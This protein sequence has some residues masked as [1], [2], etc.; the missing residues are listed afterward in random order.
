MATCLS[1]HLDLDFH[2]RFHPPHNSSCS[3]FL[4]HIDSLPQTPCYLFRMVSSLTLWVSVR[5]YVPMVGVFYVSSI[6]VWYFKIDLTW[7]QNVVK[8]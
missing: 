5:V 3:Q 1:I 2:A 4:Y 7:A 8:R 6:F